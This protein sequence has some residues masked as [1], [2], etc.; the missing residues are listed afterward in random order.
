MSGKLTNMYECYK[1]LN[2][3]K[4]FPS[5]YH[6]RR[7]NVRRI[8]HITFFNDTLQR[9]DAVKITDSCVSILPVGTGVISDRCVSIFPVWT[10]VVTDR[11]VSILPVGTGVI[12]DTDL[13]LLLVSLMNSFFSKSLI[14]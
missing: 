8:L 12:T 14:Y 4:A 13:S 10:G 11:C 1:D 7:N 5:Y 2:T 9:K 3:C 6:K